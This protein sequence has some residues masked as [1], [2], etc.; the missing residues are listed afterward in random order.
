MSKKSR[1]IKNQKKQSSPKYKAK[2]AK[3]AYYS[4]YAAR[5]NWNEKKA[6]KTQ[7]QINRRISEGIS[8]D[9]PL[10]SWERPS[11]ENCKGCTLKCSFK[12]D[13]WL[14]AD[15]CNGIFYCM[16]FYWSKWSGIEVVITKLSRKQLAAKSSTWVR[17]PPTPP[18]F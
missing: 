7:S 6:R 15:A 13:Q 17:I 14:L 2:Q 1:A 11:R 12:K 8:V 5:E 18:N 4:S 3:K 9:C 10:Q 16:H